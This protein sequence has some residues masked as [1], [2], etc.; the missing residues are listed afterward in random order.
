MNNLTKFGTLAEYNDF[1]NSADCPYVNVSYVGATDEVKYFKDETVYQNQYAM[2]PFT[3]EITDLGGEQAVRL[4]F[5]TGE[6]IYAKYKLNNGEWISVGHD[7]VTLDNLV[8]GDK[9]QIIQK[10]P[11][12]DSQDTGIFGEIAIWYNEQWDSL[13]ENAR[14]KFYGNVLSLSFGD[15]YKTFPSLDID[16]YYYKLFEDTVRL[17]VNLDNA[18]NLWLPTRGLTLGCFHCMFKD[19]VNLVKGPNILAKT[20]PARACDSMFEG[21]T[22]LTYMPTILA[23]TIQ[24]GSLI[25]TFK[26]CT[27]LVNTTT[28]HVKNIIGN[29]GGAMSCMFYNC[30][31]LTTAPT[32]NETVIINSEWPAE[33]SMDSMFS[34]CTSLT[35]ASPIHIT[36]NDPEAKDGYIF[37]NM[38]NEC[39]SLVTG[40][41]LATNGGGGWS[42]GIFN[43]CNNLESITFLCPQEYFNF[44]DLSG[45]AKE[46]TFYYLN[47]IG[48]NPADFV[49]A[50]W[51]C[52]PYVEP[53]A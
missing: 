11:K 30:S 40:P 50:Q 49:P 13:V 7:N 31:S 23:E 6:N 46:G 38:F 39:T 3:V 45:N 12:R 22:G 28:L 32:W 24:G 17:S 8:V 10:I 53:N 5:R 14:F 52:T 48:Y 29:V 26:D 41:Y 9:V 35:D 27:S 51:S 47:G 33:R 19:C 42:E 21:C 15:E 43:V 44:G 4:W 34:G 37:A 1:L 25:N 18:E 2:M 16:F 20:L 36:I